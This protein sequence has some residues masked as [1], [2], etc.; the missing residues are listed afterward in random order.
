[1]NI[2]NFAEEFI[3]NL[4]TD[5]LISGTDTADEFYQQTIN[6][7]SEN[8][9]FDDPTIFY[10]GKTGKKG[11]FM[12]INGYC[13]DETDKSLSLLIFDFEDTK[14]P[15]TL[16]NKQ[17]DILYKRLNNF[18]DEVC[19]GD[20]S[21]YCDA[22]DDT[23][24]LARLIKSRLMANEES[25]D[26]ILK[27][28]YFIISNKRLSTKVKKIK[29]G[30]FDE[31]PVDLNLWYLER[32][33]ELSQESHNETILIDFEKDFHCNGIPC[34][35]GKIGENL[36]YSAYIAIIPGKLLADIY[37]E[38]GSKVLE[39]NV[40]AFLGAG[41][42][43]SVNAGIKR[44]IINEP[45]RFFTYNNGIAAT[46]A[47][48]ETNSKDGQL[49]ITKIEDLQII[50]GGQTT[51][52]LAEAVLKK[53][54]VELEGIFVPMKLTVINDR[55]TVEESGAKFYDVMVE[56]IAK[57]ANSQNKVQASAFFSN[58]PYHILM[59]QM[60]KKYFAPPVNGNPNPTG[61]YYERTQKKYVQEQMKMTKTEKD[62][63]EAKYPKK[64]IIRK[65]DLGKYLYCIEEKPYIV[66]RGKTKIINSWGAEINES[67]NKNPEQ[68]NE[69][70]FKKCV[71]AAI[72]FKTVDSY[73]ERLKKVPGAWYQV[74]G[75]KLDI[76]PYTISKICHSI[77]KGYEIDWMTIWKNQ[78]VSNGLMKEIEVVSKM[79]N[80]FICDSH[81]VIV[82]EYCKK[83]DTWIEYAKIPYT[84]N[85]DFKS[86]LIQSKFVKA[87]EKLAAKAKKSDDYLKEALNLSRLGAEYWKQMISK[88]YNAKLLNYKEMSIL[89]ILVD[90]ETTGKMPSEKQ[91]KE[92]IKIKKRLENGGIIV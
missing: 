52:S 77:P 13:F 20:L 30:F 81:G 62:R 41:R 16:V 72:F 91:T 45:S 92:I 48:I 35:E 33:F 56:K 74:G 50:N 51:A 44:T 36:G 84:I 78:K 68:F 43:K 85:D 22:S 29:Q 79:T 76:V 71:A 15:S 88:G 6:I 54:N 65:E 47:F 39:G 61:W 3:S 17:I 26:K 69:I 75:Y 2:N 63:F 59:E 80:D 5:A 90:V 7:L 87:E 10:F 32:F 40:R 64:Q 24:K 8:G 67:Y 58:S 18:L 53:S 25:P 4:R 9:E 11:R 23:L 89:K 14:T 83:E 37:I 31:K 70:Y 34:I 73:L 86:E 12:Q 1:M 28:K 46:A 55:E 49:Y 60:S 19:F 21:V 66:A 57:Y 27:I 42:A 82:T 38:Y